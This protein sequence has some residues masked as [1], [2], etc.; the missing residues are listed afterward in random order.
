M[1][2]TNATISVTRFPKL[3]FRIM[4]P[5]EAHRP[6]EAGRVWA[7][8]IDAPGVPTRLELR[9]EEIDGIDGKAVSATLCP[10]G[11]IL[12]ERKVTGFIPV[13][14]PIRVEIRRGGL[15]QE[16]AALRLRVEGKIRRF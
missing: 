4:A 14:P 3:R 7:E 1:L 5:A 16:L 2:N 10:F 9:L 11:L 12:G 15:E 6:A 13:L 8:E